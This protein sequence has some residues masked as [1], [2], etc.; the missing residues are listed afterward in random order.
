MSEYTF[1]QSVQF[2]RSLVR[3]YEHGGTSWEGRKVWKA[4]QYPGQPD[5]EPTPGI[6]VGV[7]TL[8]NGTN[9]YGGYDEPIQFKATERFTAY[10][11]AHDM[12]RKPVLVL[13][14]HLSP[15]GGAA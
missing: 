15:A 8:A 4:E 3:R 1:G 13:P 5:P 7:R 14:E 2:T 12:R 11:V 10:L 6:V 9:T